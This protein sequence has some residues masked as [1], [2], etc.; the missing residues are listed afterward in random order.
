MISSSKKTVVFVLLSLLHLVF[1]AE[2]SS[3]EDADPLATVNDVSTLAQHTS[4]KQVSGAF[5]IQSSE[6]LYS[7]AIRLIAEF[8]RF[9]QKI[10]VDAGKRRFTAVTEFLQPPFNKTGKIV[11]IDDQTS[12]F[13]LIDALH[14][15]S[16]S[17]AKEVLT[18]HGI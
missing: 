1:L 15:L 18:Q 11:V 4:K 8:Q 16:H 5:T 3:A 2:H 9:Q 13:Q 17:E 7:L 12:S 10:T 14:Q 6:A